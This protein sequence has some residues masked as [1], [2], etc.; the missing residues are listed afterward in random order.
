MKY[1]AP[2]GIAASNL[3]NDSTCHHGM[4]LNV[5]KA[6][7]VRANVE[8]KRAALDRLRR[9]FLGCKVLV[10]DEVSMVGSGMLKE[11]HSRLREIT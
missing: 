8:N 7:E 1:V 6:D 3:N 11:I 4:G 9:S 2:S 10:V 5:Y